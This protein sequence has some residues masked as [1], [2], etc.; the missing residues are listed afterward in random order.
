MRLLGFPHISLLMPSAGIGLFLCLVAC[1]NKASAGC[2][3]YVLQGKKSTENARAMPHK[4]DALPAGSEKHKV[5]CSGPSCTSGSYPPL[6]PVTA[7]SSVVEHWA[8]VKCFP[9]LNEPESVEPAGSL[10]SVLS[11]RNESGVYHPPRAALS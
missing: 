6:E 5:P 11:L 1:S 9:F 10:D 4:H 8:I 3:D 7:I 2:G